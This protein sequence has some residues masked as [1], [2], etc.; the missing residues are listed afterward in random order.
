MADSAQKHV[1]LSYARRDTEY[2]L[3]IVSSLRT[4]GFTIWMDQDELQVGDIW[5]DKIVQAIGE[6]GAMI[7]L[8][9]SAAVASEYVRDLDIRTAVN[10]DIPILPLRIED[11]NFDQIP[12]EIAKIQF[13]DLTDSS[14]FDERMAQLI[15]A[16]EQILGRARLPS[17]SVPPD[18]TEGQEKFS[19]PAVDEE[20][21]DVEEDDDQD[22][23]PPSVVSAETASSSS[24]VTSASAAPPMPPRLDPKTLA[25]ALT[26]EPTTNDLLGF[27]DYAAA[28]A[29]FIEFHRDQIQA[30]ADPQRRL[31]KPLT[32][33]ID[34]PWGTGK[35]SLMKMIEARLAKDKFQTLWFNA[36]KYDQEESLWAALALKILGQ[37]VARQRFGSLRL[38]WRRFNR[39]Q[40]INRLLYYGVRLTAVA[41]LGLIA[42]SLIPA[43][44]KAQEDVALLFPFALQVLST[45][46]Q[47][48]SV[49]GILLILLGAGQ[50]VWKQVFSSLDLDVSQYVSQPN[51]NERVGFLEQFD[52]DFSK[53]IDV[54]TSRGQKPLV[55]FIDDLDRCAPPN[56]TE[57]IE[58]ISILVDAQFCIYIIG[59]DTRAVAASIESKYA[60]M[61]E[62]LTVQN[63]PGGLSLGEKFLEKIIQINFRIPRISKT[64]ATTFINQS[65]RPAAAPHPASQAGSS[66]TAESSGK[67]AIGVDF[68]QIQAEQEKAFI[69]SFEDLPEVS[70]A[71]VEAAEY[72]EYNPRKIKRFLN[73]YRLRAAIC[74]R[75]MLFSR[76][77]LDLR[78]LAKWVMIETRWPDVNM[79]LREQP[80][81][82]RRL[83]E[84]DDLR[85]RAEADLQDTVLQGQLKRIKEDE[86]M[87]RF[88]DARDLIRVLKS[89]PA[90]IMQQPHRVLSYLHL[91]EIT[92]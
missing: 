1:Y 73:D 40:F 34:A 71:T 26:D 17:Q 37:G 86:Q 39:I 67:Q 84:A 82:A 88:L 85:Q 27:A 42:L 56:S 59:M 72:L 13:L 48:G 23:K 44:I 81:F 92:A 5:R 43:E 33:G 30:E 25:R 70:Q 18:S 61:Q 64:V 74:E 9:S 76:G 11:V 12:P 24:T 29:S 54:V 80:D 68:D 66:T 28:L 4:A 38:F 14:R 20:L 8:L 79:I 91:I 47:V 90:D 89:I 36:W 15:R 22:G 55:V 62:N 83:L 50:L 60:A 57:I 32:I 52:K 65:L 10:A 16:L 6:A 49:V 31:S 46:G 2:A 21:D 51:Y 3:R 35:T 69:A 87:G 75:R 7:V 41:L 19:T 77:I 58:A 63:D 45:F 53:I 78:I